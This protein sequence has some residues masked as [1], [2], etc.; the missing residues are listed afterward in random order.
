MNLTYGIIAVVGLLVAGILGMIAADPGYLENAPPKPGIE[1]PKVCSNE[2]NPVCGVDGN[3]YDNLC[4]M[5]VEGVELSYK[6]KCV[7]VG[8]TE[9]TGEAVM[10]TPSADHIVSIPEGSGIPGCDETNECYVP[11]SLN[12]AIGETV[13]WSNDDT[14]AHTVTSGTPAD[15]PDGLFD[16]GM[17]MAGGTFEFTFTKEGTFDYYCIV[18]PWMIGE[19]IVGEEGNMVVE[20]EPEPEPAPDTPI[21]SAVPRPP[22]TH[23]VETGIGSGVPG[24]EETNECYLPSSLEILVRDNVVWDNV[25]SASHTVTAGTSA[26]GPTGL[27]DSGL[28]LS[29]TT[30]AFTFDE[31]G[32]YPYFCMVHPWMTGEIIVTE[33][34]EMIVIPEEPNANDEDMIVDE[35]IME[36]RMAGPHE[37]DMAIGSGIPG[38]E[39]TLE[40]YL[41][42]QIEISS[43]ESVLW[44]NVDSAAHTVTSGVPGSP[45]GIFDSGM[46]LSAGTFEFTFT[47]PA[48]YDYYCM[49]HPWMTGKVMVG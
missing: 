4:K 26:D 9:P 7:A 45:N 28:F 33:V 11:Y 30:F 41:P 29:G 31:T 23:T 49:V 46:V 18:H 21:S 39:E 5:H 17:I 16:S 3:T 42:Y 37:I 25:D 20:P 34:E 12:V 44:N 24:C 8:L 19:V 38:C 36:E 1:K 43:G 32:V 2:D 47:E 10:D 14:A 48:E 15:G 6:G 40:C 27:F 22:M 13:S 35:P